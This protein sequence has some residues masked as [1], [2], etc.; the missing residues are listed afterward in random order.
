[1]INAL[2]PANFNINQFNGMAIADPI[3]KIIKKGKNIK[4][5]QKWQKKKGE[6]D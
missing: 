6:K 5:N 3:Y 4:L 2:T 1:M